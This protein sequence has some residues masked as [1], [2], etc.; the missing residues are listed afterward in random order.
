MADDVDLKALLEQV[1][2]FSGKLDSF[3]EYFEARFD[4]QTELIKSEVENI[5]RQ[6]SN[7]KKN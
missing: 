2:Q 4:E 5:C 1:R 6:I 3:R 7:P